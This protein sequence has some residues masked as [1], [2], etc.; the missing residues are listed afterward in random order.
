MNLSGQLATALADC[1]I[2]ARDLEVGAVTYV[3][4]TARRVDFS[5]KADGVRMRHLDLVRDSFNTSRIDFGNGDAERSVSA[6][7]LNLQ[8]KSAWV[9]DTGE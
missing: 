9:L 8:V 3:S 1:G 5:F 4:K 2:E 6:G 7:N